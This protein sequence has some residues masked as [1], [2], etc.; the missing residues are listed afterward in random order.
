MLLVYMIKDKYNATSDA[1]QAY[2]S[3]WVWKCTSESDHDFHWLQKMEGVVSN[4]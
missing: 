4:V 3:L 1:I 2:I